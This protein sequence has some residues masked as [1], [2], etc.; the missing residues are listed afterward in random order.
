MKFNN[1]SLKT[2]FINNDLVLYA[3]EARETLKD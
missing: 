1:K 2:K 3:Y